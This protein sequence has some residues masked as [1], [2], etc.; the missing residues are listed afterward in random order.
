MYFYFTFELLL[1][2]RFHI[3]YKTPRVQNTEVL[4]T[5]D[6]WYVAQTSTHVTIYI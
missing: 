1:N 5:E 6:S 2:G 3:L 4:A